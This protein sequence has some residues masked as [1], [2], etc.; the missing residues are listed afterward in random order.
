MDVYRYSFNRYSFN[1]SIDDYRCSCLTV[2]S[3]LVAVQLSLTVAGASGGLPSFSS[4]A[5]SS[6]APSLRTLQEVL[7]T[8]MISMK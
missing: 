3:T 2:A 6:K 5:G 1:I 4:W 8:S 7:Q